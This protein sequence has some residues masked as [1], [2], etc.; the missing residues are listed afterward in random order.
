MRESGESRCHLGHPS[1]SRLHIWY[2]SRKDR[3]S[4]GHEGSPTPQ[5]GFTASKSLGIWKS[6][7]DLRKIKARE[8]GSEVLKQFPRAVLTC[9]VGLCSL[10][11]SCVLSSVLQVGRARCGSGRL[12][13]LP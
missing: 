4:K 3:N 10:L 8:Y 5:K 6:G 1:V 13:L 11:P 12:S 9:G 2:R 7:K